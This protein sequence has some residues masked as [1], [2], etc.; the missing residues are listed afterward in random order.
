MPSLFAGSKP[1]VWAPATAARAQRRATAVVRCQQ[2]KQFGA[3]QNRRVLLAG[4]AASVVAV[5]Q[6]VQ[7]AAAADECAFQ[8]AANGLQ[9]CDVVEGSGDAPVQGEYLAEQALE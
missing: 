2:E 6:Q 7:P 4:M 1:F 3:A 9:W 8:T 5:Q